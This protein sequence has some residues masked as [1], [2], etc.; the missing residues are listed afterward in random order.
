[1]FWAWHMQVLLLGAVIACVLEAP[2]VVRARWRIGPAEF[3]RIADLCT[4]AFV[5]LAAYL[6]FT[7]GMPLPILEIFQWLPLVWLPLMTAQR[8]GESGQMPVSA[9]FMMLRPGRAGAAEDRS[10]DLGYT[11][12]VVCALSAGA[13]NL[14]QDTYFAGLVVLTAWALWRL[15]P[16]HSRWF[17]WLP[18]F[19]C[20]AALGYGGQ[21]GL[22]RL[23]EIVMESTTSF[24]GG[25]RTDPYKA[26]TDI[27]QIGELKQSDRIMLRVALPQD[28]KTPLLLHRASYN[29]YSSPTWLARD[30]TFVA[31]GAGRD[32]GSWNLSGAG[33]A[34]TAAPRV[35]VSQTVD[36]NKAVL[37]LPNGTVRIDDLSVTLMQR[38]PLGAVTIET[39]EDFVAYGAAFDVAALSRDM[40]LEIDLKVPPRE[41]APLAELA[42]RLQLKGKPPREVLRIVKDYFAH[43]FRYST[44]LAMSRSQ[45]TPLTDFL[46]V[47]RAGHCEY[48]A[49][50][51]T[52]L[53]RA[54]G[55]PARYATGYS[56]QEW[57]PFEDKFIVRERH[58][59]AWARVWVEGR[60]VDFDTTPPIWF[61]AEAQD[62][63]R[64][65]PL[66][67]LWS[68]A[69]YRY[70]RW[71]NDDPAAHR[72][73]ALAL[74][75]LLAAVLI[76][77][78]FIRKPF[79]VA[80]RSGAAVTA[81]RKHPGEDSEFYQIEESLA[82]AGCARAPHEPLSDWLARMARDHAEISVAPLRELLR[83]HYRYRFDP[84]GL[85]APER[86][87]LAAE[88]RR[89]LQANA[90][91]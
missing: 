80:R 77:R 36:R 63:P 56:V 51:T 59:H 88:A 46:L 23:Q 79:T 75:A 89:W 26:M 15:R 54:A 85:S 57:S 22:A 21:L 6:T 28:L 82:R 11:Y 41:T 35:V 34:M 52:L 1:M 18:V 17:V 84:L 68:W 25:G 29:A 40:P 71:R 50:A 60:W 20:S 5:I 24:F 70:A 9:L 2:W 4:W 8:Y 83:L 76:W 61:S 65:Q 31:I 91:P 90:K 14:R 37:A 49:T 19:A 43:E 64:T 42:A 45:N 13:A 73:A 39:P 38:N 74:V 7:K 33:G 55:V 53:L 44:Y 27:G 67:D 47:T 58:A 72:N 78:L 3:A 66:A 69:L 87:T 81:S 16:P 86:A 32:R 30:V 48:F 12:A 10:I 62:A